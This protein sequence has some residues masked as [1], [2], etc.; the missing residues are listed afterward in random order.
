MREP[1]TIWQHYLD[2]VQNGGLTSEPWCRDRTRVAILFAEL[3]RLGERPT[4]REVAAHLNDAYGAS[5]SHTRKTLLDLWAAGLAH[6]HRQWRG[7][8]TWSYRPGDDWLGP[9]VIPPRRPR[10]ETRSI[11]TRRGRR[12]NPYIRNDD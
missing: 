5:D 12:R 1:Q 11:A 9:G 8:D 10:S 6:P 3:Y 7:T 2:V 4:R